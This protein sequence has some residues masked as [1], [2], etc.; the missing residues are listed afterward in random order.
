CEAGGFGL[1]SLELPGVTSFAGFGGLAEISFAAA[2]TPAGEIGWRLARPLWGHGYAT[3]A[4]RGAARFG[5]DVLRLAEIV[6]YAVPSNVRSRIVMD[7]IGMLRDPAADFE[8]PAVP[9]GHP[10]RRHGLYRLKA[11]TGS[12]S[13]TSSC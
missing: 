1:W 3:E 6:A 5:F 13:L 8:H 2:F 4:A 9:A 10:L 12:H 11:P 7:R